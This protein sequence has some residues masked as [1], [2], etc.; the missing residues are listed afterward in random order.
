MCHHRH[1]TGKWLGQLEFVG[2]GSSVI[3]GVITEMELISL[4]LDGVGPSLSYGINPLN[5]TNNSGIQLLGDTVFATA[6]EYKQLIID[7]A[8]ATWGGAYPFRIDTGTT[9]TDPGWDNV[10]AHVATLLNKA[11]WAII[12]SAWLSTNSGTWP[13][14]WKEYTGE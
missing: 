11:A 4:V 10:K 1:I 13:P 2:I 14:D 6:A 7:A 3:T 12:P 8:N 9:A 5:I